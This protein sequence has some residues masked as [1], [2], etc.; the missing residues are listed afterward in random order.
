MSKGERNQY[1]QIDKIA[2][3]SWSFIRLVCS[4]HHDTHP[5]LV[6]ENGS[7]RKRKVKLYDMH[8]NLIIG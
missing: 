1:Q 2:G 4:K 7:I 5:G 3:V 8:G 6:L